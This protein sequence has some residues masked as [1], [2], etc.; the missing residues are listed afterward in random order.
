MDIQEV[1]GFAENTKKDNNFQRKT[2]TRYNECKKENKAGI[3]ATKIF[4]GPAVY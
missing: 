3:N 2:L 4:H 1:L